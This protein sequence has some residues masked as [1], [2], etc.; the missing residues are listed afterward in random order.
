MR[1]KAFLVVA[2][3]IVALAGSGLVLAVPAVASELVPG[4]S[5]DAE[6]CQQSLHPYAACMIARGYRVLVMNFGTVD[7]NVEA[8]RPLL[9]EVIAADLSTCR[10][11]VEARAHSLE[12]ASPVLL[13]AN[14][15]GLAERLLEELDRVYI[16]CLRPRGYNVTPWDGH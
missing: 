2:R 12:G 6:E 9:P 4:A 7:A 8:V 11:V 3:A 13:P 15:P 1:G 14:A 5:G 16:A 10:E